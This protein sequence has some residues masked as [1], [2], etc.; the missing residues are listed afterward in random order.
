MHTYSNQSVLA[1]MPYLGPPVS[2]TGPTVNA[3][4]VQAETCSLSGTERYKG[5]A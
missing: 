1:D 5:F 2:V 4:G 3:Y